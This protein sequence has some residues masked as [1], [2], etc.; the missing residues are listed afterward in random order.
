MDAS[1]MASQNPKVLIT[2]HANRRAQQRGVKTDEVL[3][4]AIYGQ[5]LRSPGGGIRR[6]FTK[7]TAMALRNHGHSNNLLESA[8]GTV[9]ITCEDPAERV[10]LTVRPTEK[11]GKR[12]GG[13]GKPRKQRF[14]DCK[15]V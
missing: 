11:N 8:I 10:V 15:D 5:E 1:V 14:H 7:K 6:T 2:E 13:V 3:L 4:T 9:I 12:R